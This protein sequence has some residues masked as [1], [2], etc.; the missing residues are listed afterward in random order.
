MAVDRGLPKGTRSV[1]Q[2]F[3]TNGEIFMAHVLKIAAIAAVTVMVISYVPTLRTMIL[4]V[5]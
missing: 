3:P 2:F 5:T 4:K 1:R